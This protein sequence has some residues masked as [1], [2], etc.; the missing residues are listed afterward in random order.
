MLSDSNAV[1]GDTGEYFAA[2]QWMSATGCPYRM[3]KM[4][5]IGID[6]ELEVGGHIIKVQ[7]KAYTSELY[8]SAKHFNYWTMVNFP[9]I[10]CLVN[11][12]ASTVLWLPTSELTQAGEN[13][14]FVK[15][16]ARPVDKHSLVE[17]RKLLP[18]NRTYLPVLWS[19]VGT[20]VRA[21]LDRRRDEDWKNDVSSMMNFLE[22]LATFTPPR[23]SGTSG[24]ISG[25][26]KDLESAYREYDQNEHISL[27][28]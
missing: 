4:H 9:V 17:L 8:V 5:D 20:E 13:Y 25:L 15:D 18:L 14:K 2:Y 26:L 23:V 28:D 11:L 7:V 22:R 10:I 12:D 3:Q 1:K 19:T 24:T 21:I 6:G 16:N 27:E